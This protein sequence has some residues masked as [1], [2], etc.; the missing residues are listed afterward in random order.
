VARADL[1][2]NIKNNTDN[3]VIGVHRRGRN[4]RGNSVI[5]YD[6]LGNEVARIVQSMHKPLKCGARVWIETYGTV[7]IAY[8]EGETVRSEVLES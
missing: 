4:L 6:K 5:I 1:R 3:P 8:N 2:D 7:M